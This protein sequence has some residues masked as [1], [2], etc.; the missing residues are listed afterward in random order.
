MLMDEGKLREFVASSSCFKRIATV[1]SFDRREIISQGKLEHQ[2]GRRS[3]RNS[4]YQD[5]YNREKEISRTRMF[6]WQILENL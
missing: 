1:I 5:K 4:I 3:N 6:H 2:E